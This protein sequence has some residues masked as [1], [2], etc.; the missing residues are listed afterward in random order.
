M[1]IA[2]IDYIEHSVYEIVKPFIMKILLIV[3][4]QF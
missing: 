4:K 2:N 3:L 1:E